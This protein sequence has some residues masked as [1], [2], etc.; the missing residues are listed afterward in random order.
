MTVSIAAELSNGMDVWWDGSTRVYIDAPPELRGNVAGLCGT[1]T[2]NQKDDFLTPEG[3]V[4]QN[5]IAF[6]NKWKATEV[7]NYVSTR[8]IHHPLNNYDTHPPSC[9][10]LGLMQQ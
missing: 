1:F 5:H 8:F 9:I 10:K 2:D 7:T 3:D 4:E 6:A